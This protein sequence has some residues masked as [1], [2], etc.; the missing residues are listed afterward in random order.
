M[1]CVCV[2]EKIMPQTREMTQIKST[3][4][5][6]LRLRKLGGAPGVAAL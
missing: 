1:G 5:A 3:L 4:N 6:H 2:H